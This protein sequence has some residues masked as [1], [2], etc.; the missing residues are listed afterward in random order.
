MF[1]RVTLSI[2]G[3][4]KLS[5]RGP[6]PLRDACVK[7]ADWLRGQAARPWIQAHEYAALV[8]LAR[9]AEADVGERGESLCFDRWTLDIA[10]LGDA[11]PSPV[12]YVDAARRGLITDE[13]AVEGIREHGSSDAEWPD[14]REDSEDWHAG[15]RYAMAE[16]NMRLRGVLD[17]E[18]RAKLDGSCD[19]WAMALAG[20]VVRA[21]ADGAYH[22]ALMLGLADDEAR[23]DGPEHGLFAVARA[24]VDDVLR[25]E[26]RA[27]AHGAFSLA[28]ALGLAE[29]EFREDVIA[30]ASPLNDVIAGSVEALDDRDAQGRESSG[31]ALDEA[32]LDER[33]LAYGQAGAMRYAARELRHLAEKFDAQD[34]ESC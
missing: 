26:Q 20:T 30:H 27:K 33:T 9:V 4:E 10:P 34:G 14:G 18:A 8:S 3:Q 7:G 24:I 16:A 22:V 21:K 15:V 17:V 23:E 32:R 6:L 12:G 29:E 13:E 25:A 1:Y 19:E 5:S 31:V 28:V 11:S 2:H